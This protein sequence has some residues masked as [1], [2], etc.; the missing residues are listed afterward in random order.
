MLNF[1]TFGIRLSRYCIQAAIWECS[2]NSYFARAIVATRVTLHTCKPLTV[3]FCPP[4][5]RIGILSTAIMRGCVSP[6][7]RFRE[8]TLS[9]HRATEEIRA[10]SPLG[11]PCQQDDAGHDRDNTEHLY[12]TKRLAQ[13]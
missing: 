9:G 3:P 2:A 12:W 5:N 7:K 1:C 13:N 6:P 8:G 4:F 10:R 11:L